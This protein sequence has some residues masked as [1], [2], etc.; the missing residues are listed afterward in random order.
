MKNQKPSPGPRGEM[1]LE[2][3]TAVSYGAV[4]SSSQGAWLRGK[5]LCAHLAVWGSAI[6]QDKGP[7]GMSK[8]ASSAFN[9]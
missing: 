7:W 3:G 6:C 8:G 1:Q 9:L 2:A 5:D 4:S